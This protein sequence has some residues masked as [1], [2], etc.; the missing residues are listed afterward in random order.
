M[1]NG[2]E[3][4]ALHAVYIKLEDGIPEGLQDSPLDVNVAGI[5]YMYYDNF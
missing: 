2:R 3:G 5:D 1:Q 4:K